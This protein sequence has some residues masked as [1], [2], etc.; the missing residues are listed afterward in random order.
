MQWNLTASELFS[1]LVT[2]QRPSSLCTSSW[3]SSAFFSSLFPLLNSS[4]LV[5]TQRTFYTE[6]LLH[7]EA[8]TQRSF[9]TEK[10][11]HTEAFTHRSFYTQKLLHRAHAFTQRSFHRQQASTQ[12]SFHIENLLRRM[13]QNGSKSAA[14]AL[15]ATFM[16]PLQ[17]DLRFSAAKDQSITHT[18]AVSRSLNTAIPLR[19]ADAVAKHNG[20]THNSCTNC[21]SKTGS[22]RQSGKRRFW[23]TF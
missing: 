5:L 9:Y 15:F 21:S 12:I 14:K 2:S 20:I 19:S 7:R 8:F 4:Q 22:W 18:A 3:L 11:L 10:L 13:C 17:Y 16:Q 1:L 6:K 23:S